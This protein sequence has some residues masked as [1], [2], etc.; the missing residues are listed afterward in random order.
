[1]TYARKV[2]RIGGHKNN[3]KAG[4]WVWALA[5]SDN[6]KNS[7]EKDGGRRPDAGMGLSKE[8]LCDTVELSVV[9]VHDCFWCFFTLFFLRFLSNFWRL[10]APWFYEAHSLWMR[11][12]VYNILHIDPFAYILRIYDWLSA[13]GIVRNS[14]ASLSASLLLTPPMHWLVRASPRVSQ[15]MFL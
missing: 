10:L 1:M 14:P 5:V 13:S 4:E 6:A 15:R 9:R 11:L 2:A 12:G 3:R 8:K 7:K